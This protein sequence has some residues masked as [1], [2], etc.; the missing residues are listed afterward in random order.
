MNI[1]ELDRDEQLALGG[2]LR[3]LVRSDGDFTEAEESQIDAIGERMGGPAAI[4][5]LISDSAQAYPHDGA[6]RAAAL[7]V[8]R[9]AAREL[10]VA[11]LR[12]VAAPDGV[13]AKETALLEW[14]T[15]EW[16]SG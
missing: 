12:E 7:G 14:L 8:K 2:L 9:P 10:M 6:I 4:W 3:L 15:G 5:K 11:L 1:D 16:R 13:H